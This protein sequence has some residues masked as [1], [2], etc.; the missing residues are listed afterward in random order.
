MTILWKM[1]SKENQDLLITRYSEWFG[2]EFIP[3]GTDTRGIQLDTKIESLE[4][5]DKL[6]RQK[7]NPVAK[8]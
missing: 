6:M 4:E 5:I 1:L 3:P 8:T 7:P 2:I